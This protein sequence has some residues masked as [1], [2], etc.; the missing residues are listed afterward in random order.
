MENGGC[1]YHTTRKLVYEWPT[2]DSDLLRLVC[3]MGMGLCVTSAVRDHYMT[4]I[5]T[6]HALCTIHHQLFSLSTVHNSH[7]DKQNLQ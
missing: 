4:T 1:G 7:Y 3:N 6:M 2:L 5:H